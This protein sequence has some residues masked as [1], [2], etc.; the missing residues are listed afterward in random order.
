MHRK[1]TNRCRTVCC[2]CAEK[3]LLA[4]FL[5][6]NV[7]LASSLLLMQLTYVS[8]LINLAT[9]WAKTFLRFFSWAYDLDNT[10]AR[11]DGVVLCFP[12]RYLVRFFPTQGYVRTSSALARACFPSLWLLKRRQRNRHSSKRYRCMVHRWSLMEEDSDMKGSE[13]AIPTTW[14]KKKPLWTGK[15][16]F[17]TCMERLV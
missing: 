15:T 11:L 2:S 16:S 6:L 1:V 5:N 8:D 3:T 4:L 17:S 10:V 14:Q 13:E 9:G 12:G 7:T